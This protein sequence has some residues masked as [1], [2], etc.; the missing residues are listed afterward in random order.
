MVTPKADEPV[1]KAAR[2]LDFRDLHHVNLQFT[3]SRYPKGYV[4]LRA[5]RATYCSGGCT[6]RRTGAAQWSR[7]TTIQSL[8]LECFCTGG[9]AIWSLSDDDVARRCV[10]DLTE[11]WDSSIRRT[12]RL[13]RR[14]HAIRVSG[15]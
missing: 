12:S 11:S 8:V 14:S 10:R 5:G 9:D 6:K 2:S 13:E 1:I 3:A 15:L 7:T 4:A